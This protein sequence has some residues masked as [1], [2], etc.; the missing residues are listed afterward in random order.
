[1][2][3][4]SPNIIPGN[5]KNLTFVLNDY[6][7]LVV[8]QIWNSIRPARQMFSRPDA[9]CRHIY[10]HTHTMPPNL[11]PSFLRLRFAFC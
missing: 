1:M 11:A 10:T 6:S 5:P 3:D 7:C 8:P 4:A 9:F 2:M